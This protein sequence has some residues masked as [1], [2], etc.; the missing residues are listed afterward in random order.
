MMSYRAFVE[1]E[2]CENIR[3]YKMY[4]LIVIFVFLGLLNPITAKMTPVILNTLV[5]QGVSI[6]IP[7][8]VAIDSWMQFYKNVPNMGI[9]VFV[10]VFSGIMS[11]EYGKG[12]LIN[13]IAKGLPRRDVVLAKY[14]VVSLLWTVC[15]WTCYGVTYIYTGYFWRNSFVHHVVYAAFCLWVF[16]LFIFS[17]LILG[18]V[19]YRSNYGS[20]LFTGVFFLCM[21]LFSMLPKL[22][23]LS[24]VFLS[25]CN[26]RIIQ[27]NL[28]C[29]DT[30]LTLGITVLLS[31]IMVVIAI[32]VLNKKK[33]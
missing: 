26:M 7:E 11:S 29:S 31:V 15:Y 28:D 33:L 20:M 9:I 30:V 24:P 5:E 12:T 27:E 10:I 8:P 1:K 19:L 32:I 18:A 17:T 22:G 6:T 25:S 14:T 3:S 13:I 23:K 4:I 21:Y 2:F 16:G